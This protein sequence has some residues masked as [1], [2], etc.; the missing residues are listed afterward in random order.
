MALM[1]DWGFFVKPG[2]EE[3]FRA[4]LAANEPRFVALAPKSYEYLGTYTPLW[5]AEGERAQFH[6]LWRYGVH[7]AQRPPDLRVAAG[8]TAGAFTELAREFLQFV[9]ESR[10][11]DETFRLYTSV[12]PEEGPRGS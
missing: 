7:R 5:R 9:D 6:Q 1:S 4:W 2:R 10:G 8:D 11:E 3:A 12:V